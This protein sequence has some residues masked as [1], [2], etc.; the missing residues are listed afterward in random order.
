M[1]GRHTTSSSPCACHGFTNDN[2]EV[3]H[4]AHSPD[5]LAGCAISHLA[6][7]LLFEIFLG[8][9]K[10]LTSHTTGQDD[11]QKESAQQPAPGG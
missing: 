11:S 3:S 9:A 8:Q 4:R 1:A 5:R 2:S 10:S 7:L 6:S